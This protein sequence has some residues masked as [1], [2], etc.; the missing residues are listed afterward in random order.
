MTRIRTLFGHKAIQARTQIIFNSTV[1]LAVVLTA[2][3]IMSLV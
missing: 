3:V 2:P 1:V